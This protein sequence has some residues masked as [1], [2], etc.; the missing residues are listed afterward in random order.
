MH[1]LRFSYYRQQRSW[2]KVIFSQ[3]SVIL[4]MGGCYPS[5]HCRCYPSMPCSGGV[6]G[7]GGVLLGGLL[8]GGAG[9]DPPGW[10]LLRVVR[11]LLEYIL[12]LNLK[13]D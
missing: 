1:D 10:P 7:P 3:A 4:S 2:G 5:M 6:S 8:P 9:G 12:V 13:L 11:I